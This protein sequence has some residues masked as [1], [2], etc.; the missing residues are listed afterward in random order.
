MCLQAKYLIKKY[1][2][3]ISNSPGETLNY[4]QLLDGLEHPA[5]LD[6]LRAYDYD[7]DGALSPVG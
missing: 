6:A 3:Y 5:L 2:L 4:S 1:A 7:N